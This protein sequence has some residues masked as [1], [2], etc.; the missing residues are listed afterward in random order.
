MEKE[1]PIRGSNDA[2]SPL[3][4]N[5]SQSPCAAALVKG[6]P[7]SNKQPQAAPVIF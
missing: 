4:S 3:L 5:P 6:C 7:P 1:S 2:E